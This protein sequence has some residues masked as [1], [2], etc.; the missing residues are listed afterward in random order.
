MSLASAR[1]PLLIFVVNNSPLDPLSGSKHE[2]RACLIP[3]LGPAR[4][5]DKGDEERAACYAGAYFASAEKLADSAIINSVCVCV[6]FVCVCNRMYG[7][8]SA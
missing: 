7:C 5:A 4:A 1:Q 8:L 3:R 6:V 2:R